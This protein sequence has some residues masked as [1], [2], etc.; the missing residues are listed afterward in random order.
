[1]DVTVQREEWTW[2]RRTVTPADIL[3]SAVSLPPKPRGFEIDLVPNWNVSTVYLSWAEAALNR[4]DQFG[5]DAALCYA[6]RAVCRELDALLAHNYLS[7]IKANYPEKI[8][9]LRAVGLTIRDIIRD[10]VIDPRNDVEHAYSTPTE[11]E[12]RHGVELSAMFLSETQ[13]ERERK[14]TLS[15]G[16]SISSSETKSSTREAYQYTLKPVCLPMMLVDVCADDHQV[17]I[18]LPKDGEIQTCPVNS[19]NKSEAIE[20]ARLL[21]ETRT[22][23]DSH[24]VDKEWLERVKLALNL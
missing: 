17:L 12:A 15:R 21:R 16:W 4:N 6:K 18:I 14:A 13:Q 1:M 23:G 24:P 22:P 11:K 9:I 20:L 8:A 10:L 2:H 7:H 3:T 5:W 19:F